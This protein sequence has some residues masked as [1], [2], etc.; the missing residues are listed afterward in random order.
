MSASCAVTHTICLL[1]IPW[2]SLIEKCWPAVLS[3]I[4]HLQVE[5]HKKVMCLVCNSVVVPYE[6][7]HI[8]AGK[9]YCSDTAPYFDLMTTSMS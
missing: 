1:L 5:H 7:Y 3:H 6:A 2:N 9:A 4:S 8:D